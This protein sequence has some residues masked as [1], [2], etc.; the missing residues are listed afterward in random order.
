MYV[1]KDDNRKRRLKLLCLSTAEP[2][3][4]SYTI[5]GD[6]AS[7]MGWS[8]NGGIMYK[9]VAGVGSPISQY[10]IGRMVAA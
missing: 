6:Q 7:G 1:A 3:A 2:D 8:P 4:A 10:Y 9:V 5:P